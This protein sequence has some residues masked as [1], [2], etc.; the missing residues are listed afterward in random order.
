[1]VIAS[2]VDRDILMVVAVADGL[3]ELVAQVV[4]GS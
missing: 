2:A 3:Q 1:M 4:D